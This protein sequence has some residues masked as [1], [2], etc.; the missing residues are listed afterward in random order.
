MMRSVTIDLLLP[1]LAAFGFAALL[2]LL[3]LR[4]FPKIGLLDFPERYGLTRK[5]LPYPTGI[6]SV[7]TFL[8]VFAITSE[9]SL[10]GMGIAVGTALLAFVCLLDD[11]MRLPAALRLGTQVC[12]AVII[13]LLGTRIYTITNP[14]LPEGIL[15]LDNW[16]IA[17]AIF[18]NPPVWSG[19]FTVAWLLLTINALNWFDGIPGQVS[20]LSCIGFAVI[21][22]LAVSP[23]VEHL[24]PGA[25]AALATLAFILSGI[26]AAGLLFDFPPARV[27]MGDTGAMFFGLMLGVLTIYAGGKVATAFLVLGVPLIDSGIVILKRMMKGRSPLKGSASGEHLHHLLLAAGW[28]DRQVVLLTASIGTAFGVTALFLGTQQK[29]AAG[30]ALLV[31]ILWLHWY[32]AKHSRVV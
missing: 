18:R 15:D 32:A 3:A 9:S 24:D 20:L 1:A 30:A 25:Q 28:S 13:F 19:L 27:L 7:C 4:L 26:A 6:L 17:S 11:R 16:V 29:I 14:L 5:R 31:L 23:R 12:V 22:M 8:F 10:Q 21:G 2:H